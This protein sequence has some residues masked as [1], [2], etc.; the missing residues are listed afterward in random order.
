MEGSNTEGA[1]WGG[2]ASVF[3]GGGDQE[4]GVRKSSHKFRKMEESDEKLK[5]CSLKYCE[6]SVKG[7]KAQLRI[8]VKKTLEVAP[9]SP[10]FNW[11]RGKKG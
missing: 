5:L 1:V 6:L 2:K 4:V 3:A 10:L 7:F 9:S 11:D 8:T